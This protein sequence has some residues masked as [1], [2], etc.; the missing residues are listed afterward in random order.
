MIAASREKRLPLDEAADELEV[1][2][3][4]LRE[5]LDAEP[6]RYPLEERKMGLRPSQLA[7]LRRR[8]VLADIH[9]QFQH[10]EAFLDTANLELGGDA[11]RDLLGTDREQLLFDYMM[12][13]N[14][15]MVS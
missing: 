6:E 14:H 1:E 15:G 9:A 7:A 5:W 10:P 12:R 8:K 4:T 2:L 3:L 13:I 11:P